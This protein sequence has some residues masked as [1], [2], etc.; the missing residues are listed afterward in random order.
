MG[1]TYFYE[2][3][4]RFCTIF[5]TLLSVFKECDSVDSCLGS[6]FMRNLT[7][8]LA[9]YSVQRFVTMLR[10]FSSKKALLTVLF[11]ERYTLLKFSMNEGSL[12]EI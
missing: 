10:N 8:K 5:L 2:V 9:D 11:A 12:V 7:L 3:Y 6:F 1:Q 4:F